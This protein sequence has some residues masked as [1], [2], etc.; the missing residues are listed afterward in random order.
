M[1][2]KSLHPLAIVQWQV[3]SQ[4]VSVI[5]SIAVHCWTGLT[6]KAVII[7]ET[8]AKGVYKAKGQG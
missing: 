8:A 3:F 2:K 1:G 7:I 5:L 6:D 4:T